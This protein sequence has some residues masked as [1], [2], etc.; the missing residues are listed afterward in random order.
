[1]KKE[2]HSKGTYVRLLCY[3]KPYWRRVI[4]IRRLSIISAFV[5]VL[6]IQ[7]LGIAVDEIRMADRHANRNVETTHALSLPA[8]KAN[9]PGD[10]PSLKKKYS[11]PMAKPLLK[12]SGYI[13][14]HWFLEHNA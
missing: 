2:F 14:N 13:H 4:V 3:L 6:P 9:T 10:E 1:M 11:I 5:A 12:M 7:I 8:Q